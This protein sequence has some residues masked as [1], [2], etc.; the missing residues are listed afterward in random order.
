MSDAV[1]ALNGREAL[2]EVAVRDA[3]LQGMITLRGDLSGR[4]LQAV[5][6]SLTGVAFPKPGQVTQKAAR[7]LCWM[8]PDELLILVPY[9][10]VAEALTAID[11]ALKGK[12]YLAA[13]ASDARG[14]MHVSGPFAREVI[15]KLAPVDLHPDAFGP[16][17][18]RRSRLGQIA[19]AFWMDEDG[20]FSV[21]CFRSVA[22]YAFDL[23]ATSAAAGGVGHFPKGAG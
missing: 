9:D 8:S 16:G 6:T 2:G 22:D 12:H 5:C 18:F 19:A 23:L 20:Q 10:G 4:K 11:K 13:N 21:I 7:A 1:S 3:G 17:D 15:A 14:F